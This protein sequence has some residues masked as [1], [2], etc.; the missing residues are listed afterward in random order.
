MKTGKLR[1]DQLQ[2][3][4]NCVKKDPRVPVPPQVGYDAGV[5]RLGNVYVA[6][7]TDPCVGVPEDWFGF[8]LVNYAASDVA[9]FGAKPEFCTITLLGP[10]ATKPQRFL[11]AMGQTCKAAEELGIA[12]VRGHTGTYDGV[13]ELLGVC[14]AYG[15]V[16][17]ER[18]KTPAYAKPGDLIFCSKPIGLETIVNFILSQKALAKSLF[19]AK[20][21]RELS[22]QVRLQSCVKEALDLAETEGVHAMH[23]AT[24]GGFVAA[25]NELAQ[26]SGLGFKVDFEKLPVTA[27][28]RTLQGA[29]ELSDEQLLATS[30]TGT[31]L[32]SVDPKSEAAVRGILERNSLEGLVVGEFTNAKTRTLLRDGRETVFPV[33]AE[34]PYARIL[35]GKV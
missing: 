15:T 1:S 34:D 8:L 25:L 35:S 2:R 16:A 27:E 14:T 29:F 19:G 28:A 22:S 4:L 23:D 12:I 13:S 31:I 10:P 7:A 18:L 33:S 20:R 24:E 32:A 30:S 11:T 21:A 3:L 5:H 9:L 6:V 17:L 26:A